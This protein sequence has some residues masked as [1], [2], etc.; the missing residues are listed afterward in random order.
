M[1]AIAETNFIDKG[2]VITI[3]TFIKHNNLTTE[4]HSMVHSSCELDFL[5][6]PTQSPS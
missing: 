6:V 1:N 5:T 4:N 2:V 3:Y